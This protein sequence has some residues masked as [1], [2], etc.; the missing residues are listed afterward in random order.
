MKFSKRMSRLGTESAFEVLARARALEAQ[1]KEIIHLE[2]GE[3]D[4]ETPKHIS[5]AT[6]KAL[7]DGHTRYGPAPG[8]LEFRQVIAENV[9]R[10]RGIDVRPEHVVV[11][12]GGKPIMFF[13]ILALVDEGDEVIYPDPG[14][15]IY[16][17][18]IRFVGAKAVPLP[19]REEK[20]FG[21]DTDELAKL[22]TSKTRM[23]II[24][25]PENPT[26]GVLSKRDLEG[27]ADLTRGK[28]ITILSDEV[29]ESI[30]YEGKHE[31]IAS[32]P[33]MQE[34]TVILN[35]FSKTYSMGG[36]RLGYGV[37]PVT[38]AEELTKLQINSTSCPN[39]F[40]QYGGIA[41][42]TSHQQNSVL[43][44]QEFKRRRDILVNGLNKID[45]ITC[46]C[47]RGAFFVFPN[48][49]KLERRTQMN[50]NR[51][52]DYLLERAGVAVIPGTAFGKYGKNHLRI[53]YSNSEKN[54]QK[55]LANIKACL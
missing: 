6:V 50:T 30:L 31:S 35:S 48:V 22:I 8:M 32:L 43:M 28:E 4:F 5:D 29:Y 18:M 3:P 37:M 34:Q 44:V 55:A 2:L 19:L 42:L 1:G 27:I 53:S 49:T 33:K 36:W 47:P 25:S 16:E 7:R 26:G 21:F 39:D 10:S 9:S 38:L 41:A 20:D 15:P 17:S 54:I 45:G 13:A 12:P 51:L 23:I 52:A 40:I 14:F 11:T 46:L 24:N